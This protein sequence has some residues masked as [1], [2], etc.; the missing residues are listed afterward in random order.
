MQALRKFFS[1]VTFACKIYKNG[2]QQKYYSKTALIEVY[3]SGGC[4]YHVCVHDPVFRKHTVV[5][6]TFLAVACKS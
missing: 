1:H 6:P 2:M 5:A 3:C 4:S